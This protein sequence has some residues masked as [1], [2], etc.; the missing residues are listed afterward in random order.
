M[1]KI[2][3]LN[4]FVLATL[5]LPVNLTV[6]TIPCTKKHCELSLYKNKLQHSI[7]WRQM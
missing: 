2:I 4:Y 1:L 6:T 3:T 5:R 7:R